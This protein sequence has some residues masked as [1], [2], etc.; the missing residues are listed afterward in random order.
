MTLGPLPLGVVGKG[1]AMAAES[2]GRALTPRFWGSVAGGPA[3]SREA[4]RLV[5]HLRGSQALP[6]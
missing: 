5:G 4:A 3:Q 1:P 6:V 2:R